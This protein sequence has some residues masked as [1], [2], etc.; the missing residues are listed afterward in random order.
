MK[1]RFI[2]EAIKPVVATV[3]AAALSIGEPGLPQRFFWRDT[4]YTVLRLI[5]KWKETGPCRSGGRER[6]VRKH[7]FRIE[8][9]DGQEM[10]LFFERQ[11]RSR[12][13]ATKRWWLYTVSG[14]ETREC[15]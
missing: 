6:Y 14:G 11:P 5:E 4:E 3:D 15:E 10:R 8:T 7:W 13:E 1:D 9:T 2:C 12:R